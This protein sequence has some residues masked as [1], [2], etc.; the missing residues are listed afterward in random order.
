MQLYGKITAI[1]LGLICLLACA[2]TSSRSPSADAV[3]VSLD[4]SVSTYW[5]I[6]AKKDFKK[7]SPK[8]QENSLNFANLLDKVAQV[9]PKLR[10]RF[11]TSNPQDMGID[12][13]ETVAK[14]NNICN[15]I[16]LPVQSGS[17][18]I[19]ALMNRGYDREIPEEIRPQIIFS[20]ASGGE[21]IIRFLYPPPY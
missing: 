21:K 14:H 5:H 6:R 13:I 20:P 1:W 17:S 10:I 16:H 2:T 3:F 11:S 9:N 12:V 19:L 18:R 8:A 7:A 15:Y 4:K